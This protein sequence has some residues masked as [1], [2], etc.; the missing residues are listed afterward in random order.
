MTGRKYDVAKLKCT[1]VQRN[2]HTQM[3]NVLASNTP[4]NGDPVDK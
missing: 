1:G 2:F 4:L 3:D